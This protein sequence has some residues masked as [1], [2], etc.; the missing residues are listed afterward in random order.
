MSPESATLGLATNSQGFAE[1]LSSSLKHDQVS[2][3]RLRFDLRD[4][5]LHIKWVPL[6]EFHPD[7][8]KFL[9]VLTD[10]PRETSIYLDFFDEDRNVGD[11]LILANGCS[12]FFCQGV[13]VWKK[14]W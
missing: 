11:L 8:Y 5:Y 2:P 7:N 13:E 12:S 10:N 9:F 3:K 14:T 6:K 4:Y 1:H